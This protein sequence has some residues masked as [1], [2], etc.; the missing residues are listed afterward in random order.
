MENTWE[1]YTPPPEFKNVSLVLGMVMCAKN[2]SR[3]KAKTG[4]RLHSN[5]V[6]KDQG[7]G[8]CLGDRVLAEYL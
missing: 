3:W 2:S 4:T 5:S 6:P 8:A 7:L 1:L